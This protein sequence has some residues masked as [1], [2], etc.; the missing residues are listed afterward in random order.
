MGCMCS[1]EASWLDKLSV[2]NHLGFTFSPFVVDARMGRDG[3]GA[4]A[5][6]AYHRV[7][8]QPS[9]EPGWAQ[10]Q[11]HTVLGGR[12]L[13]FL[14]AVVDHGTFGARRRLG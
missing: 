12:L 14:A 7:R 2:R 4:V 6:S 8:C 9:I 13:A 11:G 1:S 5:C 10:G 3:V